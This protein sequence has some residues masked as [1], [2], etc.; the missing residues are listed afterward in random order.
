MGFDGSLKLEV[1]GSKVTSDAGLLPYLKLDKVLG[2]AL[3]QSVKHWSLI[4]TYIG[5]SGEADQDLPA[6]RQVGAKVVTHARYVMFQMAEV[7]APKR[8]FRAI[9]E[10]IE[11]LRLPET[12]PR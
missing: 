1:H 3:P 11:R 6:G 12:V 2:L 7:A 9:L 10:R 8:L 4:P 5:T